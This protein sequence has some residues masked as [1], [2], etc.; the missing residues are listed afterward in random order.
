MAVLLALL[1]VTL[2]LDAFGRVV[3][4]SLLTPADVVGA[5]I[6]VLTVERLVTRRYRIDL[7][8]DKSILAFVIFLLLGALSIIF[9]DDSVQIF[10]K[11]LVQ[12]GGVSIMLLACIATMNEVVR[13]PVLFVG[14][15]RLSVIVLAMVSLIGVAQFVLANALGH[16]GILEFSFLN[17]WSGGNVWFNLGSVDGMVRANSILQEPSALGMVLGTAAGVV[18]I[19][20]GL[21]GHAHRDAL[22]AV[23]P[24]WTAISILAGFVVTLSLIDFFLLLVVG[25]SLWVVSRTISASAVAGLAVAAVLVGA[26]AYAAIASTLPQLSEK[27]DATESITSDDIQVKRAEDLSAIALAVNVAVM[28]ANLSRDPML[29]AGLGAHPVTYDRENPGLGR[30][31]ADIVT[32]GMNKEDAASLLVR[33]LSESGILGTLAFITGWMLAVTRARRLVV[34]SISAQRPPDPFLSLA[35]GVTASM[36]GVGVACLARAPQY[37]APW[38]W[39]PMALTASVPDLMTRVEGAVRAGRNALT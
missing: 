36:F 38:F 5:A 23:I 7:R 25:G 30:L 24:A 22:R 34:A 11:G 2:P 27:L 1:F 8:F 31:P 4:G 16:P 21:R 20:L 33:L 19:R 37:Y 10:T 35:I 29:G 13:R 26:V 39:L 3:A 14:Y 15:I 32:V 9:S 12:I 18:L 6:A 17:R 28:R